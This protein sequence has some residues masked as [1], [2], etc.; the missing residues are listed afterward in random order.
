MII[1]ATNNGK[2]YLNNLLISFQSFNVKKQI[3][4]ID[5]GSTDID[6][7]KF[8]ED[9]KSN[10]I[11]KDLNILTHKTPYNGFDSGAYIY[12]IQNIDSEK[13]YF[14]HDSITLKDPSFFDSIDEKLKPG[15]V[16][17]LVVFNS[18]L[19]DNQDQIDFSL[20]KIGVSDF[21]FGIFGPM[22]A[23]TKTDVDKIKKSLNFFP[24]KKNEQ[25]AME[26]V[27]SAL[28]KKY[29]ILIDPLE[30]FYNATK[31]VNKEYRYFNKFLINRN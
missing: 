13:Y 12:A 7:I 25:M 27:W 14:L 3:H 11:F 10:E 24:T 9:I 15:V 2:N 20:N 30:G 1:I 21:D 26:R 8:L 19:Y 18:N 28:F 5:T 16:V 29:N 6:S 22:F 23:I 31:I 17:P 4:V